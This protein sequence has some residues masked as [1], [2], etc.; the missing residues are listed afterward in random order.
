MMF[1]DFTT[2]MPHVSA[3][4]LRALAVTRLKRSSLF[5]DLPTWTNPGSRASIS[6][7]G[8]ASSRRPATPPDVVAKLNGACARSST[9]RRSRRNSERRLRRLFLDA[10]RA[11]RLHQ[12]A[13]RRV[14]KMV[15]DANIQASLLSR[16]AVAG[17]GDRAKRGGRGADIDTFL[18]TKEKRR[19]GRPLH[20]ASLT[21]AWSPSPLSRGRMRIPLKPRAALRPGARTAR[22]RPG[23][24]AGRR[25][26]G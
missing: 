13:A 10:G 21:L 25:K 14:G 2:A 6:T 16:P 20:H 8:P 9:A 12:G 11:R 17:R 23:R 15:K 7:P 19:V 4:T 1:A 24:A 26:R 5:P 3:G 22:R 18:A